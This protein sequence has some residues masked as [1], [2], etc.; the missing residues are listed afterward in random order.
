M[1]ALVKFPH[2]DIDPQNYTPL[3]RSVQP[4]QHKSPLQARLPWVKVTAK[5]QERF[6]YRGKEGEEHRDH[7]L[8]IVLREPCPSRDPKQQEKEE[9]SL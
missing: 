8:K 1:E 9:R 2:S 4:E 5:D 3:Q 7:F 6:H